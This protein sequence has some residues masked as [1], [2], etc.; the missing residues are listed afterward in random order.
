MAKVAIWHYILRL[1][2]V[3]TKQVKA[4]EQL[5]AVCCNIWLPPTQTLNQPC[6]KLEKQIVDKWTA[7]SKY[8]LLLCS[9][10]VIAMD[11]SSPKQ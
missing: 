4:L 6:I 9:C 5:R 8:R 11:P 3:A 2:C 10:C 7:A 1:A